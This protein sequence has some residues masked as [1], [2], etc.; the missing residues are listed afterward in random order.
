MVDLAA[1]ESDL[2]RD[3]GVREK[4]YTDSVGKLSIGVGRN[5][6]D[7]GLRDDEIALMLQNDIKAAEA[8]LDRNVSWWRGMPEP[9]QRALVNM[10]FNMGIRKLLGFRKMLAALQ[11][12]NYNKAAEEAMDS[13]WATQV[14]KRSERIS[15]LYRSCHG[16][17]E[18]YS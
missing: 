9:A 13:K 4:P 8:D 5:L 18:R 16:N 7:V 15:G 10:A 12:N 2:R 3:E 1:L 17:M 6:D 14:G 11:N